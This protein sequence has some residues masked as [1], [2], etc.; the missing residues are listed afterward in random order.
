MYAVI[1][2]EVFR[3]GVLGPLLAQSSSNDQSLVNYTYL[4]HDDPL[5]KCQ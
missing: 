4:L 3:T 2:Y 1:I 5:L